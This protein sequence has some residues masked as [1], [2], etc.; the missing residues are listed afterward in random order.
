LARV[1]EDGLFTVKEERVLDGYTYAESLEELRDA[2][3]GTVV[4]DNQASHVAE[5]MDQ[6]EGYGKVAIRESVRL[7]SLRPR[8][9]AE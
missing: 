6:A 3:P 5:V 4:D 9:R 7:V 1:V 2:F 8:R